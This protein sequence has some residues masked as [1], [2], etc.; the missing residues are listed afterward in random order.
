MLYSYAGSVL[1]VDMTTGQIEK[2]PLNEEYARQ[3]I[4]G[5][6][7][8]ARYLYDLLKPGIDPLS[9]DNVIIAMAGPFTGTDIY[10]CQKYE[11]LSKSPLTG[12]YLCSNSG[13]RLGDRLK[14]SGYDGVIIKGGADSPKYIFIDGENVELRD[15]SDLW[16]KQVSET[17]KAI[18]ED[19]GASAIVSTGSAADLDNPVKMAGVYD[20]PRCAGRGGLGA[21][22]GSKKLKAIAIM[23]PS[24]N[25]IQFN[26]MIHPV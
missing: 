9:P 16:G 4:G 13:G 15:A 20:G 3:Y 14:R 21:V 2:Q 22:F 7:L 24:R 10:A 25:L 6:G 23:S 19:T 26:C 12:T 5:R 8:G 11:W 17:Q 1:V 18:R